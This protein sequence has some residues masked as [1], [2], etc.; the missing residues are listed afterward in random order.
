MKP[1][2]QLDKLPSRAS[3]LHLFSGGLDSTVLLFNM[4]AHKCRVRALIF[5]YGQKHDNEIECARHTCLETRVHYQIVSLRDIF[6]GSSLIKGGRGSVVVPN[7]N[8][9]FLSIAASIAASRRIPFVT[10]ASNN[11]DKIG[12]P[13]CRPGFISSVDAILSKVELPVSARAPY[14]H[15]SKLEIVKRGRL[16]GVDFDKTWSCYN[17]GATPCGNCKACKLRSSAMRGIQE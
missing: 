16:L 15:L 4:L 3:V 1:M 13:D 7:R 6:D 17:G 9:V 14:L 5:D 12:F 10:I 11:D 2:T 8:M